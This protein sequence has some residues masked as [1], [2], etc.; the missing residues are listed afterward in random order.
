MTAFNEVPLLATYTGY[1]KHP[2]S[3]LCSS[4]YLEKL[5]YSFTNKLEYQQ[6]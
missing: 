6:D 1:V 3:Q 2:I 4:V 5:Y